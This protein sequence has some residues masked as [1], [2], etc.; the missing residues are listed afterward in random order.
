MTSLDHADAY[1][2]ASIVPRA[3]V[4]RRGSYRSFDDHSLYLA[5][6]SSAWHSAMSSQTAYAPETTTGTTTSYMALTT[7]FTPPVE[8]K[9]AYMWE[10]R[11]V[12]YD[13]AYGVS[14][15]TNLACGPGAFTTWWMQGHLGKGDT[16]ISIGPLTCPEDWSTVA[17]SIR[18]KSSTLQMC[19]PS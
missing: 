19:C 10:E 4:S 14:V 15:D 5:E 9:S 8:C 2:H 11:F 6:N 16:R 3:L 1:L 18:S 17:S 7:T 13:P 12:V